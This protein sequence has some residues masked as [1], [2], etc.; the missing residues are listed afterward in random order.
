MPNKAEIQKA[1]P[2]R[3]IKHV[4][5]IPEHI[6]DNI[7]RTASYNWIDTSSNLG[8]MV[9]E[10]KISQQEEQSLVGILWNAPT[11]QQLG[12]IRRCDLCGHMQYCKDVSMRTTENKRNKYKT[13]GFYMCTNLDCV[14]LILGKVQR[15]FPPTTVIETLSLEEKIIRYRNNL[16]KI[17]G[18]IFEE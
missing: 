14:G 7:L 10:Y 5:K 8:Y 11:I 13:H 6:D 17:L 3:L 9:L 4:H 16:E 15:Q 2:Q 18:I 1:F 12:A